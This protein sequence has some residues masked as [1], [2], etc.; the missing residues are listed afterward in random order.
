MR[1][2]TPPAQ[3]RAAH[4]KRQQQRAEN[5]QGSWHTAS[6][7]RFNFAVNDQGHK[8]RNDAAAFGRDFQ[9]NPRIQ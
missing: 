8:R 3:Q 5:H 9:V 6:G 2:G 4:G 7:I 1:L